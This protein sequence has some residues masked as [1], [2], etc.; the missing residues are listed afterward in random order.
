MQASPYE[1]L[2]AAEARLSEASD[3]PRLDAQVLLSHVLRRP[4]T[5]LLAHPDWPLDA[6][7]TQGFDALVR[8]QAA[9]EPLAYLLGHKEFYGL[10]F[11]VTPD[12]LIPRPE[13]EVLV[14]R[15]V[16]WLAAKPGRR[17]VADVGT[18]SGCIAISVAVKTP[19][20]TVLGTD[21]SLS[22]L[23]V[24]ARNAGRHNV[25]RQV[26]LLNCDLLP[27]R[28]EDGGTPLRLDLLCANLPYIP[29]GQ[30]RQLRIYGHEPSL[31][32]DGGEDGLAY[33]R[34]L[35][36]MAADW[37]LPESLILLEIE[38]S[39]GRSALSLAKASFPEA[40]VDVHHDL[41]GRD[42]LLAI[43]LGRS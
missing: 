30:L 37:M 4:R 39:Q 18:G 38:A 32:L 11:E 43:C 20:A 2:R 17:R 33:I 7:L 41:A 36:Q 31:S 9:G 12:V 27:L 24:A 34:R 15:A 29:A 19:N 16:D 5:W 14:E 42:R 25:S 40:T 3:T 22:A 8:R 35:L 28:P 26:E 6:A 1:L 21:I 10:E 23:R 13:T